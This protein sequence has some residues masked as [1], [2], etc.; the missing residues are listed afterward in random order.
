MLEHGGLMRDVN[1]RLQQHLLEIRGLK[2]VNQR[3]Q[4]D[5]Q[6]CASCAASSTTTGRRGA[7]WRASGSVFRA[8]RAGAV[9][10]GGPL[11]AE[12]ARARGAPEASL[13]ENLEL[14]ELVLLLDEARGAGGEAQAAQEAAAAAPAPAAPSTARPA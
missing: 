2:D 8:P 9:A 1:R 13:R 12:A 10:R 11:A 3:L 5:N 14:K 4:D 6:S 7:S